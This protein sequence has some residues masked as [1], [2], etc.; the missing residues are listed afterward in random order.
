MGDQAHAHPLPGSRWAWGLDGAQWSVPRAVPV[1]L[2]PG[3]TGHRAGRMH[4]RMSKTTPV[5][6]VGN[7]ALLTPWEGSTH[8]HA[9]ISSCVSG[10]PC[11]QKGPRPCRGFPDSSHPT[12]SNR[13][14]PGCPAT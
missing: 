9:P 3:E 10:Q 6:H 1:P 13:K 2:L 5:P 14:P 8:A 11:L 7:M 12:P 4:G